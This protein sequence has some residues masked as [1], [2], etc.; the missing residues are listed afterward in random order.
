MSKSSYKPK[1]SK[2]VKTMHTVRETECTPL[3]CFVW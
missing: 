2:S 3:Y 1:R